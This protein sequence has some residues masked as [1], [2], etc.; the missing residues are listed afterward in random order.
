MKLFLC[1]I[2]VWAVPFIVSITTFPIKDSL[3][4]LFDSIM[5][6]TVCL[7]AVGFGVFYLFTPT[8][9]VFTPTPNV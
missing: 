9:K 5:S 1:G 7:S 2:G 4:E 3:P 8:P 6:I